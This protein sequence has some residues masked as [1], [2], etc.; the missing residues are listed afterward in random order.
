MNLRK[1]KNLNK[2]QVSTVA[3]KDKCIFAYD[4]NCVKMIVGGVTMVPKDK[5]LPI[6]EVFQ[7]ATEFLETFEIESTKQPTNT[8][9]KSTTKY[10]P[11]RT[12]K[13]ST[14]VPD[15]GRYLGKE[16]ST[17]IYED[18]RK[19]LA[20]TIKSKGEA[21]V[22]DLLG[23]VKKWYPGVISSTRDV[24][25]RSYLKY[26]ERKEQINVKKKGVKR[27][28]TINDKY[29]KV[30]FNYLNNIAKEEKDALKGVLK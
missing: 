24:Y 7:K 11:V 2:K 10:K 4:G 17:C 18:V 22:A 30:D 12:V 9:D 28:H 29:G 25:L 1:L 3:D 20:S 5:D 16:N 14:P 8:T 15:K 26:M 23:V 27:I 6:K 21:T 13:Q 19:A